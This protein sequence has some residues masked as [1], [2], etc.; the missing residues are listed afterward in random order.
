MQTELWQK[1]RVAS[2]ALLAVAMCFTVRPAYAQ[3]ELKVQQVLPWQEGDLL[4]AQQKAAVVD[5]VEAYLN[6]LG[7]MVAEFM[8]TSP[9]G[10]VG[11]GRF[12][13][14]RPGKLRWQYDPPIP[15]LIVVNGSVLAY[16]DYELDQVSHVPTSSSLVGLFARDR[17]D[18]HKDL[19]VSNIMQGSGVVRL[20]LRQKGSEEEGAL[21][22]ILDRDPMII[23]K[24]E[25]VDATGQL[26]TIAFSKVQYGQEL[27][28]KLFT[29]DYS[30]RKRPKRN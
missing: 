5:R 13:L 11:Y 12:F 25:V 19:V 4:D 2:M 23:R 21:S 30:E 6:S 8:Q 3:E 9:D 1:W 14:S 10:T 18:L 27:E 29:I 16:H 26:T 15:I 20:T 28:D 17:I 24:L 7:T 22:L